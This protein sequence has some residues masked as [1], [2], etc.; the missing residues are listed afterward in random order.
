MDT[1]QAS[2]DGSLVEMM[3]SGDKVMSDLG[4]RL[5]MERDWTRIEQLAHK[6]NDFLSEDIA[7]EVFWDAYQNIRSGKYQEREG[8]PLIAYAKG[9]TSYKVMAENRRRSN[10]EQ[11]L[12]KA[13]EYGE[14]YEPDV[15][16]SSQEDDLETIEA[17][18]DQTPALEWLSRAYNTELSPH[19]RELIFYKYVEEKGAS[20]VAELLG[21]K[22]GTI[23]QRYN[24][25][26]ISLRKSAQKAGFIAPDR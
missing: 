17:Q 11:S 15:E 10:R 23:R 1:G 16:D 6:G 9:I 7:Q 18:I 25:V 13:G 3:R 14:R 5:W 24:R 22:S 26:L 8:V 12:E 21:E 20:E 2:D 4:L 19:E